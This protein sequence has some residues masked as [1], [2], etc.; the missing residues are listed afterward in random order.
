[1][2]IT[3]AL[4]A[5]LGILTAAPDEPCTDVARSLHRLAADATAAVPTYL[6]LSLTVDGQ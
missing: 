4:A 2:T 1:V 6:G 3:A 5:D